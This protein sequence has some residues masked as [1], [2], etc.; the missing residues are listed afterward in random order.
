MSNLL[1]GFM[2]FFVDLLHDRKMLWRLAKNDLRGRFAASFLGGMWAF[3]QPLITLLVLWFVFQVG[4][5]NPPV[6]DVPFI[7]WLAPAYLSWNFFS[8]TLMAGTNSLIEY[9]YLVKKINFRVSLIPLVKILSAAIIHA[10]FIGIIG[11]LMLI[12]GVPFSIYNIQVVYYFFCTCFFLVGLC[13]LFSAI[14][15]FIKDIVNVVNVLVQIGFWA[16]PIFWSPENM[17]G[18]VQTVLKVNPMFYIC[19]G[20]RD[21]FIDHVWFWERNAMGGVFWGASI[22]CF[23]IGAFVFK[24]MRPQFADVL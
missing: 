17:D 1:K 10:A 3:V 4:F 5:R 18:W 19:R 20:Y 9:S 12:C 2:T 8:E 14:A 16:T 22:A 13:W 7:I 24:K 15:P 11:I 21:C 23:V 6:N